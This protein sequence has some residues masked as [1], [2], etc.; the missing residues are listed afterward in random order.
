MIGN[1]LNGLKVRGDTLTTASV[2]DDTDIVH[3]VFDRIFVGNL[4]HEG[5][6]RLQSAPNESLVV[7]FDGYG[8]NFNRNMGAGITANGQLS[9]SDDRVGG[10]L[11]VLGQPGFPVILTSLKDDTVGAGLQPNGAP[12]TDTNN[13]GIGSV[14]QSADWRGILLDQY[15]NDRNVAAVLETESFTAAAPGPNGAVGTAQAL[16]SLAAN[17]SGSSENLRLGFSVEGVLSQ[18]EDVDVYSF[19]AEA[20]T[21][22]WLDVDRT[23]MNVDLVLEL[24]DANGSLIA[25]SDSSTQETLNPS[26]IAVS[27]LINPANVNPLPLRTTGVRTTSGGLVKEDG[28]TNPS[29]PGM[30]V[31]LPGNPGSRSTFYFRIRS[32]GSDITATTTGLSAGSYQVQVRLREQQE[33]AGSTVDFADIRYAT[34]G[35][36]L[37]GLP[38]SSP[39]MGEAA[40]D[41]NVRNGQSFSN[42][43]TAIGQPATGNRPQYIGNILDTAKGAIS[44]AGT[45]SSSQD[46]DFYQ[47]RVEQKDLVGGLGGF[48]PVVFDIDYADGLNRPD[49]SINIFIEEN[50]RFGIQYRLIYSGDGSNIADDQ[51]RP[52]T[53]T[54][55][56]DFSRG[57]VGSKDGYIGPIALAEGNYVVGISSA[58]YQPRTKIL[59]PFDITPISSIR[60]IADINFN[61]GVTTAAPPVVSNFLP[62]RNV[63]ATGELI[64]S[65]FSLAGYS[66][67][68]LPAVYLNYTHGAG[69]FEIFVR[70]SAGIETRVAT[71]QFPTSNLRTGT[72]LL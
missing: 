70:D 15:S 17:P 14:P 7:K 21:Q 8:S 24:L 18:T 69:T 54:D 35:V 22:I 33:F 56:Q 58:A 34:N 27:S 59:N 55:L 63:G 41:E 37:V 2:W 23:Q 60:R 48:A 42:N 19:T 64:S 9:G 51:K 31:L 65:N 61:A 28:T 6:L 45:L 43:G 68:D 30:R 53:T 13:D 67:E 26:L 20:G 4:Q 3:V 52:L 25:R 47:L 32:A 5:G 66:A 46:V 11:H 40:E 10:T 57:S 39:L 36:H 16:G 12:Q 1:G 38:D 29:D 50:S 44:V 62:R 72:K 49:T 71:T